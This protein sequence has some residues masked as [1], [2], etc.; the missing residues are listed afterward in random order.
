MKA[1]DPTILSLFHLPI[2][3]VTIEL[4]LY[5][6]PWRHHDDQDRLG[7]ALTRTSLRSS[8]KDDKQITSGGE[9]QE[10]N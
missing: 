3:Q 1:L 9:D 5:A 10:K 4:L 6:R 7:P 2:K 8:H